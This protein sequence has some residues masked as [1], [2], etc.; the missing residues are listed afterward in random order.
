MHM[1][2]M[3]HISDDTNVTAGD[4]TSR[5]SQSSTLENMFKINAISDFQLSDEIKV[6][7]VFCHRLFDVY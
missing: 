6:S 5:M 4:E 2:N 3:P 1:S 7:I